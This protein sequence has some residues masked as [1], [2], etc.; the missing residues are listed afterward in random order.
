MADDA[1]SRSRFLK[2]GLIRLVCLPFAG[3]GSAAYYRWRP[4]IPSW[5]ELK[6]LNIPGH[7]GRLNERPFTDLR[8]L[9]VMLADELRSVL[10]RPLVL[11]G[12]SLGGWLAFELARELR[13]RGWRPPELMV[14]AASRAPHVSLAES[15]IHQLPAQEFLLALER[16][17]GGIAPEISSSPELLQ[18]LLPA[19]RA[20]MQMVE[21]YQ[22]AEESPLKIP[23]L[24][25]GGTEDAAISPAQLNAWQRHTTGEFS[26][27]LLPGGHFFLFGRVR[28]GAAS[29]KP[30]HP[31]SASA[32]LQMI[33]Q[34]I[35]QYL[36][37][38]PADGTV[39]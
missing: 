28:A 27:R 34:R 8:A 37:R 32:A 9:A 21:T 29:G 12:H 7:D 22:Y 6:P 24:A 3:G 39:K 1:I 38:Q 33:I 4:A 35:E 25:L 36:T 20:D 14:V 23:I 31:S 15:P 2:E 11:L 19:L 16:R 13:R 26:M 18:L 17:Y 10:D 5:I 30:G